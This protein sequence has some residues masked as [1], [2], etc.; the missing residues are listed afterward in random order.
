MHKLAE[1]R[2][3]SKSCMQTSTKASEQLI[4][5]WSDYLDR[6]KIDPKWNADSRNYLQQI[7]YPCGLWTLQ[8]IYHVWPVSRFFPDL[9]T[10]NFNDMAFLG[11]RLATLSALPSSVP[12]SRVKLADAGFYFRGQGDEVQCYRCQGRYSGWRTGDNPMGVHRRISPGCPHLAEMDRE[13]LELG[14]RDFVGHSQS[15]PNGHVAMPNLSD[16]AE[17]GE[18]GPVVQEPTNSRGASVS[19][20]RAVDAVASQ[21]AA[22]PLAASSTLMFPRP[23]L[24]LGGAVYPMYQDMASRRRSYPTWDESRAP[25]LEQ[26]VLSGFYYAGKYGK[27][28]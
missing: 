23:S 16:H 8:A 18:Q 3:K 25:P 19:D 7:A 28:Q 21:S 13:S 1:S 22:M 9:S 14:S 2:W 5:N 10:S 26:M 17:D 20:T 12:V 27:L 24:D 11:Y 15:V 4:S 6:S